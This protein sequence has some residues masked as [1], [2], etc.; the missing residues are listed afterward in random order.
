MSVSKENIE[1]GTKLQ[2]TAP[3]SA[4]LF[5]LLLAC[6]LSLASPSV[7]AVAPDAPVTL[8]L[9]DH[10]VRQQEGQFFFLALFL[11]GLGRWAVKEAVGV[12]LDRAW[13]SRNISDAEL[14]A[15]TNAHARRVVR[16]AKRLLQNERMSDQEVRD[17]MIE[18]GINRES[19]DKI[20][21]SL[22]DMDDNPERQWRELRELEQDLDIVEDAIEDSEDRDWLRCRRKLRQCPKCAC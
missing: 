7:A 21:A 19:M 11:R 17:A 6:S 2:K 20:A 15:R 14:E 10:E 4:P 12:A 3:H 13:L 1:V 9:V 18:A 16:R 22:I 8:T 5:V